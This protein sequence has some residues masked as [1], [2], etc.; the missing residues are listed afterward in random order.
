MIGDIT[1][2]VT[3]HATGVFEVTDELLL[4]CVDTDDRF[5]ASSEVFTHTTDMAKLPI[6]FGAPFERAVTAERDSLAIG[7]EGISQLLEYASDPLIADH[8]SFPLELQGDFS[9]S[10]AGPF[11]AGYRVTRSFVFH[12]RADAINDLWCFF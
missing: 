8:N 1:G 3:P 11:Q 9:G 10:L 4:F 6:A 7:L 2:L 12:K 5:L